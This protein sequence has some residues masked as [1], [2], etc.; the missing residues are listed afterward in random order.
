MLFYKID[1]FLNS[2]Y[3]TLSSKDTSLFSMIFF[4]KNL[5]I[6]LTKDFCDIFNMDS[7]LSSVDK[8]CK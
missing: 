2:S 8:F 1:F 6:K 7:A 5:T 3:E 4:R